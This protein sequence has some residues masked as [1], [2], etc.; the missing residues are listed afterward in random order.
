M[1]FSEPSI[2][3]NESADFWRFDIGLNVI[4]S[5]TKNKTTNIQWSAFQG[6]PVPEAL[7]EQWKREEAFNK[8]IAVIPGRV[9]HREDKQNLYFIFIDADKQLVIHYPTYFNFTDYF[10]G[11]R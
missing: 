1:T 11:T 4:P 2:A 8:G 7:Y 6:S 10:T 5:D 9:W 3:I